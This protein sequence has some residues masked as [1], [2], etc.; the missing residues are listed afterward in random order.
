[1]TKGHDHISS[2]TAAEAASR[3]VEI[4]PAGPPAVRASASYALEPWRAPLRIPR[5][6]APISA[7]RSKIEI[8]S[9]ENQWC[10]KT[11]RAN[12]LGVA[13]SILKDTFVHGVSTIVT[14]A[15]PR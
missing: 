11:Y 5:F 7:S 15:A 6:S 1:M 2:S 13:V 14:S 9:I 12:C 10:S 8:T 3:G 4:E